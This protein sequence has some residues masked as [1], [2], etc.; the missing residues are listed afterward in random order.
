MHLE[1]RSSYKTK[2]LKVINFKL[3]ICD[4]QIDYMQSRLYNYIVYLLQIQVMTTLKD[5]IMK[6]FIVI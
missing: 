5:K 3:H 1:S 2:G 6:Y 4:N